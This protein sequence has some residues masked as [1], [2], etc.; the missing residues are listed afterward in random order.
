M[1]T[2]L[3]VTLAITGLLL[4]AAAVL[5]PMGLGVWH[6]LRRLTT[7]AS[8]LGAE[9]AAVADRAVQAMHTSRSGG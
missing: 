4:L 7:E 6:A 5:V 8:R 2:A 1:P 9:G 3:I